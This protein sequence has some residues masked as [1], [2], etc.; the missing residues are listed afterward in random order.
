MGEW[1]EGGREGEAG[2]EERQRGYERGLREWR[3]GAYV[4]NQ[5]HT[6]IKNGKYAKNLEIIFRLN[7]SVSGILICSPAHTHLRQPTSRNTVIKGPEAM[8]TCF[9]KNGIESGL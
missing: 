9:P 8:L 7:L 6:S 4:N 5:Y 1:R 3:E 2:V